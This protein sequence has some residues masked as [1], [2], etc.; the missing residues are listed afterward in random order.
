M[1]V[2]R[3]EGEQE[4][5]DPAGCCSGV[6][7]TELLSRWFQIY[8]GMQRITGD[9]LEEVERGGGLSAPEFQ[10]L[11]HL[12]AAPQRQAPMNE[13]SRLLGF[14]TAGTTKLVDRL[15]ATGLVERRTSPTD[16]RVILA[17]LTDAG[18]A[19]TAQAAVILATGLRER[20]V[21]PLGEERVDALVDAFRLLAGESDSC[22]G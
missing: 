12:S 15:S 4:Q 16:R 17:G 21:G 2:T 20:F 3:V 10:M 8:T 11:W 14:S 1:T 5:A 9:L 13:I 22:P 7:D 19:A 6:A 18:V